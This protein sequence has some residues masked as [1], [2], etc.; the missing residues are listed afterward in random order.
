[1][2]AANAVS[3]QCGSHV[4]AAL[5]IFRYGSGGGAFRI[6]P[7]THKKKNIAIKLSVFGHNR[8]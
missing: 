8:R 7:V 1:M 5:F 2:D 3:Q 6:H 4:S